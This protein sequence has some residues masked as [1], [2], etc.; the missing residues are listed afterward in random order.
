MSEQVRVK[1]HSVGQVT[2]LEMDVTLEEARFLARLAKASMKA[3]EDVQPYIS[4]RYAD[5]KLVRLG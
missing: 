3:S 5:G 2:S 1:I 4:V